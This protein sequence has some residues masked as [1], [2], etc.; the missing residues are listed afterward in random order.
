MVRQVVRAGLPSRAAR[1]ERLKTGAANERQGQ[2][3]Q[4]F[5]G[6]KE[7]KDHTTR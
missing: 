1:R 4:A 2:D 3:E 7:P 5:D 6:Q